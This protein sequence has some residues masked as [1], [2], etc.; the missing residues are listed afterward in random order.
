MKT[1]TVLDISKHQSKMDF[2]TAKSRNVSAVMLR[3]AYGSSKDI[4]FDEF[5][6]SA[7][8]EGICTGA[9][10]FA[11]W[12]YHTVSPSFKTAKKNVKLQTEKA[13]SFL[14]GKKITAPV[15]VDIELE[16][17]AELKFSKAELT[18]L[19]NDALEI[20]RKAGYTPMLYSSVA[21]LYD[22]F[23]VKKI[24]CPLWLA[25]Y[26]DSSKQ[27]EFPDTKYGR[28]LKEQAK[29]LA[30]WQY[31]SKGD[32]KAYGAGSTYIDENFCY[33]PTLFGMTYEEKATEEKSENSNE[34]KSEKKALS[35]YTVKIKSGS[36]YV[37]R[38]YSTS[39]EIKA[40]IN[41]NVK[42]QASQKKN[43]WFYLTEQK[44]WI[45]PAAIE[46]SVY[47][48]SSASETYTVKKGDTLTAISK[49][50]NTGVS[51]LVSKNK[52]RYPKM[53]ADYIQTGWV[54]NI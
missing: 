15:A 34:T 52:S 31:S 1:T 13:L 47:N 18:E 28:L 25:Y 14:S 41:G 50:F 42:L 7:E 45:G 11:T 33:D 32:G 3:A 48:K 53:T 12:H 36:W 22:R 39:A 4:K 24:N 2:K 37:R 26:N 6:K 43:G 20:I 49:L 10:F 51:E 38:L 5:S 16:K 27:G 40:V 8:K 35:L 46:S 29:M 30:L 9:Y 54:L 17:G 44:G 19:T 21:W 23:E